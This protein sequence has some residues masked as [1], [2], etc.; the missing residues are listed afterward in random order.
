M[1][2]PLR[3]TRIQGY[4]PSAPR[5]DKTSIQASHTQG[6]AEACSSVVEEGNTAVQWSDISIFA[7]ACKLEAVLGDERKTYLG[8]IGDEPCWI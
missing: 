3:S 8:Q 2:A 7:D 5:A 4:P 6:H 1:V